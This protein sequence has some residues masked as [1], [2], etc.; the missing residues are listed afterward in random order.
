MKK[1]TIFTPNAPKPIGPYSQGVIVNDLLFISGQGPINS[2][3]KTIES[4]NTAEQTR[5]VL[6]NIGAILEVA[7][8]SYEDVINVSVFLRDIGDFNEM[9][10]VYSTF[11]KKDPPARTTVEAK[12]PGNIAV[13]ISCIAIV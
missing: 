5:Q 3:S 1:R 12:M 8:S 2:K 4:E 7:G 10:N 13:E 9:N 6:K 11:F